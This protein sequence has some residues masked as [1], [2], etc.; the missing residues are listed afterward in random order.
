MENFDPNRDE[1]F[2][3]SLILK[4]QDGNISADDSQRLLDWREQSVANEKKYIE[5]LKD[6]RNLDLLATYKS[7]N[8]SK[9]LAALHAKIGLSAIDSEKKGFVPLK[10][11]KWT[12]VAAL[13]IVGILLAV[14]FSALQLVSLKAPNGQVARFS[15]PD[16]SVITLNAGSE[17]HYSNQTYQQ[18]RAL[19]LIGGECFLE[20]VHDRN[21]PFS[22]A[23]KDIIIKDIGTSFNV[24]AIKGRLGVSVMEGKVSIGKQ[25]SGSG[26]LL[27]S[28]GE[29]ADYNFEQ[30]KFSR[31][32]IQDPNYKAYVDHHFIFNNATLS[33]VAKSI[34]SAYHKRIVIEDSLLGKRRFTAE[35]K[36]QSFQ[37]ITMV[38]CRALQLE[39]V[40]KGQTTYLQKK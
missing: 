18:S 33:E 24:K 12:A 8:T 5:F 13:L 22:I 21:R 2:Y 37:D 27:L 16:G 11:I 31:I 19:Q 14:F 36:Q 32:S 29:H 6:S 20:V 4:E 39:Q 34:E 10:T 9:S 15:L 7:L 26:L 30:G 40:K 1:N 38:I 25:N 3:I 17:V 28:K 35:F 23:F